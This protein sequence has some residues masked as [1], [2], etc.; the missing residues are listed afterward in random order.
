VHFWA[1][2]AKIKEESNRVVSQLQ[3]AVKTVFNI[4][5]TYGLPPVHLRVEGH[6]HKTRNTKKCWWLFGER[7]KIIVSKMCQTGIPPALLHPKGF[8]ASKPLSK[9][10]SDRKQD[11]RV[12]VHVMS[13]EEVEMAFS[14]QNSNSMEWV[15][16][17]EEYMKVQASSRL[18][19]K[20]R[21]VTLGVSEHGHIYVF[22]DPPKRHGGSPINKYFVVCERKSDEFDATSTAAISYTGSGTSSPI[23]INAIVNEGFT[24]SF[25]L[26]AIAELGEGEPALL[27]DVPLRINM[28]A[29]MRLETSTQLERAGSL[30]FDPIGYLSDKTI[31]GQKNTK[32]AWQ[33][34]THAKHFKY[35]R[36][37]QEA[38]VHPIVV[39]RVIKAPRINKVRP[40]SANNTGLHQMSDNK[41]SKKQNRPLLPKLKSH[42][43]S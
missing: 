30:G 14:A 4:C 21:N 18:P 8:G 11:R 42:V 9:G 43:K 17:Y 23:Q 33:T 36:P 15:P 1:G 29:K 12:E 41:S 16:E 3:F 2:T 27:Y 37:Q 34:N 13:Q 26:T 6:V 20:P 38:K 39:P 32:D 7:A 25:R 28:S 10:E 22:F 24:Y 31:D 5:M 35:L 19:S 40:V